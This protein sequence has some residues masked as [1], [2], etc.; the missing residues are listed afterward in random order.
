MKNDKI[1]L[2]VDD[3]EPILN[4]IRRSL[5]KWSNI[6]N[7]KIETAA[8]A[9]KALTFLKENASSVAVIVSDQKMPDLEGSKLSGIVAEKYPDIA[10]IILSGHSDMSDVSDIVKAGVVSFLEKPWDI[11][12]LQNEI[13]KALEIYNLRTENRK[14]RIKQEEE[15]RLAR[16]FQQSILTIN[17]PES[18]F[19]TFNTSYKPSSNT[20]IGGDYFDIIEQDPK[21][22]IVLMGD[23]SGHGVQTAFLT[24]VLKSLIYPVY[25][26]NLNVQPFI[27]SRF[28]SW[29][30][31]EIS[32]FLENI[33]EIF[34]TFSAA[35]IDLDSSKLTLANAG[36]PPVFKAAGKILSKMEAPPGLVLGVDRDYFYKEKQFGIKQGEG[37]FFCS[38]GIYPSGNDSAGFD[39]E[40]FK[41][42]LKGNSSNIH[43]H[44]HIIKEME[45]LTHNE[46]WDDDITIVSVVIS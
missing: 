9:Y 16:N 12:V 44:K 32:S 15:L 11:Q 14:I 41:K 4:S 45:V 25:I 18:E 21:H 3:E 37:L 26:K 5:Y 6:N 30:N 27:P 2:F 13:V 39:I 46:V 8:S 36:Q 43:D 19:I 1:I 10:M 24:A 17:V 22:F 20:G 33:P 23:V 34:I 40:G 28:L 35:L 7:L 29:L 38:D 31:K 42:V